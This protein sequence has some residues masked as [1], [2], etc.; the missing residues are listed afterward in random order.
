MIKCMFDGSQIK[1]FGWFN[2]PK[3]NFSAENSNAW[4]LKS[5]LA[6]YSSQRSIFK[7]STKML[8]FLKYIKRRMFAFK[9]AN[10]S[11]RHSIH[12]QSKNSLET[13]CKLF[14]CDTLLRILHVREGI[15]IGR[16]L[17]NQPKLWSYQIAIGNTVKCRKMTTKSNQSSKFS[18]NFWKYW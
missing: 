17:L 16:N 9:R 5:I 3:T 15:I 13:E 1:H 6:N 8:L 12:L 18:K 2:I 11:K 7:F 10:L 14:L 4:W